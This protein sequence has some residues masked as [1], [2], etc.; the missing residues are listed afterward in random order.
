MAAQ[1]S[2]RQ[3]L[4]DFG[5][6]L[7]LAALIVGAGALVTMNT[8]IPPGSLVL[9]SPGKRVRAITEKDRSW[10]RHSWEHYVHGAAR[11]RDRKGGTSS[12]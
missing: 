1:I 10:I 8:V 3:Q 4:G 12:G 9:G 5:R 7:T 2:D 6:R 11:F